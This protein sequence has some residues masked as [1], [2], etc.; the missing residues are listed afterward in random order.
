MN[1]AEDSLDLEPLPAQESLADRVYATL[2]EKIVTGEL[3][4]G[5]RLTERRVAALLG[6]SPTPVHDALRRLVR[7]QIVDR[8]G[9]RTLT[10][11]SHSAKQLREMLHVRAVLRG[12][13]ARF[14]ADKITMGG[15]E[16]MREALTELEALVH[17]SSPSEILAA[18]RRFD[19]E[20]TAAAANP[21]LEHQ[22]DATV[23]IGKDRH[24]NSVARMLSSDRELG[25]NHI[26]AHRQILHALEIRD[27]DRAERLVVD[28][29]RSAIQFQLHEDTEYVSE[30]AQ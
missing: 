3:Q 26:E 12:V 25:Q 7:E 10:V 1:F 5:Q 23:V 17:T 13:E 20:I 27:A 2:R 11:A 14:A 18:A 28:L 22:I 8:E 4:P 6:V 19:A 30:A 29:M 21:Q 9:P 24:V 15:L 16:R